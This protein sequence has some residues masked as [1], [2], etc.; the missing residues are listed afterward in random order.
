[1][2][3]T[4]I[5]I[6]LIR[7]I[8]SGN[9]PDKIEA[10]ATLLSMEPPGEARAI[11]TLR[12]LEALG[13]RLE[14]S[15]QFGAAARAYDLAAP[16]DP[17]G[18]ER[19]RTTAATA[20]LR[21]LVERGLWDEASAFVA[22]MRR[23]GGAEPAL[24]EVAA[25]LLRVGWDHECRY[26]AEPAVQCYRLAFALNG[27]D[28]GLATGDGHNISTKIRNL[29]ILQ[30]NAL[31][32]AG[33]H[34]E[35]AALHESTRTI[36]GLGPVG[37]YDIVS[38]RQAAH[39][40]QGVYRELLAG[41]RMA[42]PEVRFLDGPIALTSQ[43]GT[44]DAPPQYVALFTDCLTFPR[45]NV[46]L[47]GQRLIYDLAAHPLSGVADI[48]DGVNP[49]QIMTAVWGAGR[50]LIEAPAEIREIEAGLMMFGFQSR[51]Y[52]HWLLEFAPRMLWFNDP[53]C[54][55]HLPICVDDHMPDTHRQVIE[56]MDTRD[57]P[58]IVLP[59]VATR[60]RELGIAPVP[61]F[62]PFDTREGLPTY[63]AIWP[64]DVLAAMRRAILER[65]SEHPGGLGPAGRRIVLSR[66]GFT[67]RQLVNEA[68]IVEALRPH[69]F[70]VV[71]PE[72]LTF[73]EQVRLYH[74]AAIIV[75]S[76]S[77]ALI[78]CIFC[79]PDAQ[80]VAL[81]HESPAFY[82][83][84]FTSFVESSGARLLF[85]RGATQHAEGVHPMHANYSVAPSQ[86]LRALARTQS[87]G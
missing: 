50:A 49:G 19:W 85:V 11:A 72:H 14:G 10:L 81:T 59:P 65:L 37:I 34:E 77:S 70:E 78:N 53:A 61:A 43:P 82:F 5:F 28:A 51:Q 12:H 26:R 60:F 21:D 6:D 24:R 74:S 47:H 42:E 64:Q 79:R 29:R 3:P 63:D 39:E 71:H 22:E 48:K 25:T 73:A 4:A 80:V 54:P 20:R 2:R 68:E 7:S 55:A 16:L 69:G 9:A 27:G 87:A 30:M 56:L 46:V 86:I 62:F 40:G 32:E 35:A 41:R 8:D 13:F 18:Q 15:G 76:A 75:G 84:G 38:A 58:V 45:S 67:Q 17:R 1:M 31:A 66:R 52:G 57:R 83:R 33:R 44:L 23:G 36:A